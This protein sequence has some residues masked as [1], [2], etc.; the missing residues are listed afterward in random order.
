MDYPPQLEHLS[1]EYGW[2]GVGRLI[3]LKHWETAA[4]SLSVFSVSVIDPYLIHTSSHADFPP[5]SPWQLFKNNFSQ[6]S[7]CLSYLLA[8]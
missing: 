1:S 2:G 4:G 3:Y 8:Y 5:Y 7:G 6:L